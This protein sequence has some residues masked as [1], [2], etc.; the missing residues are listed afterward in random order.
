MRVR[1]AAVAGM[2]YPRDAQALA[3]Q[4]REF[5]DDAD[6]KL[7]AETVVDAGG[8][9]L[10]VAGSAGD[11]GPAWPVGAG[12]RK[13]ASSAPAAAGGP[14][15]SGP[16]P[17]ALIVPHAGYVY[18]GAIA[19]LGYAAV[20]DAGVTRVVLLGPCHR[21]PT[22]RLAL[23]DAD[24]LETPLGLATVWAAGAAAVADFPQV[25]ANAAAH[26]Q[27]HSLEVQL[28][29]I[30]TVLP[31]AEVLPLAVGQAS[32]AEVAEVLAAVWGGPETLIAVSSD[33]SHYLPYDEAKRRDQATID[34]ILALDPVGYEQACGADPVNGLLLACREHALKLTL[35]GAC[36]SGDT[37]GDRR[38]VVGYAAFG[39]YP[40]QGDKT[41]APGAQDRSGL[42]AFP[43]QGNE[44]SRDGGLARA[45]LGQGAEDAAR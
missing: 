28:P 40:S 20:R 35:F 44:T 21:Y 16:A 34:S 27:E 5:V 8:R 39:A 6:S 22:R 19:A 33:L 18:S 43:S 37:A 11:V 3:A 15:A 4:V 10:A 14:S 9:D 17:K 45:D 30:Q 32:P 25:E 1:P 38:R 31:G 41:A 23:P 26:A 29:F 24:A 36:N 7:E 42:G 13:P 12:G 2:F